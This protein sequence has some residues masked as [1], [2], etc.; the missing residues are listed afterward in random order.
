MLARTINLRPDRGMRA[1]LT[2]PTFPALLLL[3]A[4][5]L[6]SSPPLF[7]LQHLKRPTRTR[8]ILVKGLFGGIQIVTYGIS[9][10]CKKRQFTSCCLRKRE[11]L[12]SVISNSMYRRAVCTTGDH[13][14]IHFLLVILRFTFT[15]SLLSAD[16]LNIEATVPTR[17]DR[18][19]DGS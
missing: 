9:R 15:A 4:R 2:A 17:Y 11:V 14:T 6:R 16:P 19:T 1:A 18:F 3:F 13:P 5:S 12:S 8:L 7:I 10:T